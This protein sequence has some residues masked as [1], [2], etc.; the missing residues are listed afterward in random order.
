MPNRSKDFLYRR[1][2]HSLVKELASGVFQPG[3]RF[4]SNRTVCRLWQVSEPTAKSAFH[5]LLDIELLEVRNRSGYYVT[6]RTQRDA[7]LLL[8]QEDFHSLP[9]PETWKER[10]KKLSL[11]A[12]SGAYR[13]GVILPPIRIHGLKSDNRAKL[14]NLYNFPPETHSLFTELFKRNCKVNFFIDDSSDENREHIISLMKQEHLHGIIAIRR[15]IE[16]PPLQPMVKLLLKSNLPVVTVFDDCEGL[17]VTSINLNNIALGYDTGKRFQRAGCNRLA[18]LVPPRGNHYYYNRLVGCR[19]AFDEGSS[20]VRDIIE[21]TVNPNEPDVSEL[22]TLLND[23]EQRINGLFLTSAG[24]IHPTLQLLKKLQLKVPEDV[25]VL[26]VTGTPGR[27]ANSVPCDTMQL[28]FNE[29][30]TRAADAII[31]LIEGTATSHAIFTGFSYRSSG[32]L[33][34]STL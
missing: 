32:T 27:L 33:R 25:S 10:S 30:G 26:A 31:R 12:P 8:H 2:A 20:T 34:S 7:M 16:Y 6:E 22:G 4:Y 3:T 14:D 18:V 1:L 29:V 15:S 28:D 19:M 9:T 24:Y 13:I 5:L 17:H 21:I 23:P 11:L